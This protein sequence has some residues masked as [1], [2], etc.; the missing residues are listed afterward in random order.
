MQ[1]GNHLQL[2][3]KAGIEN[4]RSSHCECWAPIRLLRSKG[5]GWCISEHREK[6]NQSLSP[7]CG[8]TIHCLHTNTSTFTT[9]T[10]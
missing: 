3:G 2:C 5:N 1:A 4:S 8:E 9:E 6:H 7:N 10:W